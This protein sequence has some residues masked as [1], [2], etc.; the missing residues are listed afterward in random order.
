M[1]ENLDSKYTSTGN[2][3]IA[4]IDVLGIKNRIRNNLKETLELLWLINNFLLSSQNDNKEL[5][6]RSFSDNYIIVLKV[7]DN[8]FPEKLSLIFNVVGN[9]VSRGLYLYNCLLRGA[10]TFGEL[11]ID[12]QIVLGPALVSAYQLESE[13]ATY[14]RIIIEKGLL[15]KKITEASDRHNDYTDYIFQDCDSKWCLNCLKFLQKYESVF[16]NNL[17]GH[18]ISQIFEA[19][20][21]GSESIKIKTQWL[22][23]YVNSYY[24][25][26]YNFKL[27]K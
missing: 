27:I 5:V 18:V 6:V 23:N 8:D 7:N 3:L 20:R 17:K 2:Y 1:I 11:H 16:R 9:L 26:N 10:I 13:V 25:Q 19:E 21:M 24:E 12:D 22:I 4:F 15:S 14:P